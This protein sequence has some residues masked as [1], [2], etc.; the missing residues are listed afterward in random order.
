M[1]PILETLYDK[2]GLVQFLQSRGLRMS[3]ALG[4]NFLI[5][6]PLM[7]SLLNEAEFPREGAII[8]IGPGVGHLTW[9]LIERGLRVLAVEKDRTFAAILEELSPIHPGQLTIRQEDA[10]ETDFAAL[11][12]ESGA[13]WAI[14]NLP[15]N[16]AVP[17]LFRLAY[18]PFRFESVNVML[19]KEVGERILAEPGT[20]RYGRLSIVLNY[21]Y[22]IHKIRT[23]AGPSFFPPPKVESVFVQM[24]PKEDAD[25]EL[26]QFYLERI[27][28]I[29]FLHRRKKLRKQ[30][31]GAI[32]ERRIISDDFLDHAPSA[33]DFEK[34]AE[35]WPV[36][37]WVQFA[38]SIRETKPERENDAIIP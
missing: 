23:I 38:R 33:F 5:K 21:L 12:K 10:L 4:Q 19:Q 17:I 27:V 29:G 25:L 20:K 9:M 37:T 22:R 6:R 31:Q 16:V 30:L 24:K 8:E 14:G 11:A 26:A 28:K 35:E 3:R 18:C 1:D 7:R 36:E 15:Y 34:R 32:I 13:R 2:N